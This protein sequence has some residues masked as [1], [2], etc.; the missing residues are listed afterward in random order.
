MFHLASKMPS[1]R[2]LPHAVHH[3]PAP[4]QMEVS[5]AAITFL[6]FVHVSIFW[7]RSSEKGMSGAPRLR[8]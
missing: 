4:A 2:S 8:R 3:C 5:E 7:I 1:V 6:V